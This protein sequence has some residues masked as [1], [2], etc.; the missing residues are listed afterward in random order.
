MYLLEVKV[1]NINGRKKQIIH[2]CSLICT[3]YWYFYE[4]GILCN[5]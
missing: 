5:I 3:D 4:L 1:I 2:E